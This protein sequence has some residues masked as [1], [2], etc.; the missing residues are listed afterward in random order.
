MIAKLY[1]VDGWD[2]METLAVMLQVLREGGWR[3]R[4]VGIGIACDG[5]TQY[6]IAVPPN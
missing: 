4:P 6:V 3:K 5:D 2:D 1:G